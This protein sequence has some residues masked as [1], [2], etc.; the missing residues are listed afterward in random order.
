VSLA[1]ALASEDS[2]DDGTDPR[3]YVLVGAGVVALGAAIW[4]G[5]VLYRRRLP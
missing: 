4:G 2:G 1:P 5:W 3:V